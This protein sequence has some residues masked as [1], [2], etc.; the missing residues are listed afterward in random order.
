M[1]YWICEIVDPVHGPI[2]AMRDPSK[3]QLI[4]Q[5]SFQHITLPQQMIAVRD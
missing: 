5:R 3:R 4:L 2:R 1:Y